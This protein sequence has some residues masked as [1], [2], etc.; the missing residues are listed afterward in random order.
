MSRKGI[1]S[2]MTSSF[3]LGRG[4]MSVA[5]GPTGKGSKKIVTAD[6]ISLAKTEGLYA[7]MNFEGS[8]LKV[9]DDLNKAYY[10]REVRPHRYSW[11]KR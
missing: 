6:F 11:K 10:G 2:L 3:K 8:V 5:A 4:D 7:G 9:G 1:D